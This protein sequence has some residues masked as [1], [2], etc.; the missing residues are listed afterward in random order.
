MSGKPIGA[1][2][3]YGYKK[4]DKDKNKWII[5]PVSSK[6]VKKIFMLIKR[7]MVYQVLLISL[8]KIRYYMS[9]IFQLIIQEV[10]YKEILQVSLVQSDH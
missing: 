5:D 1:R 6:V 2:A 4:D 3:P 9:L 8:K 7:A 10:I